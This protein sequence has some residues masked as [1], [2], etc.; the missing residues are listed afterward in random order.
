MKPKHVAI[1][2]EKDIFL[3]AERNNKNPTEVLGNRIEIV[4]QIIQEQI[5]QNI[6]IISIFLLK[7][8]DEPENF[9]LIIDSLVELFSNLVK[10]EIISDNQI[11]VS[12]IGKWYNL[13]S[14]IVDIIKCAIDQTKS[15]DKFFLNFCVNY[16]GQEE[17]LD[18]CKLI[19]KKVQAGKLDPDSINKSMIK[20]DIYTSYFIAPDLAIINGNKKI[21]GLL[22]WDISDTMIYFTNKH[23]PDFSTRD[24][25]KALD[26]FN[27]IA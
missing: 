5:D 2:F 27:L 11:K 14:R 19:A 6:P 17:I 10:N 1:S 21:N 15:Y 4:Q 13:P 20:E 3:W 23:W 18:A 8:M 12:V 22:Q 24:F 16:D 25:K 9:S 26:L 7:S